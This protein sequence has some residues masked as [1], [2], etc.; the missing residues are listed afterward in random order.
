MV[1]VLVIWSWFVLDITRK[2]D[3]STVDLLDIAFSNSAFLETFDFSS[4]ILTILPPA[5]E[6]FFVSARPVAA[7]LFFVRVVFC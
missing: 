1:Q 2:R 6:H 4:V 5:L 3:V 7:V